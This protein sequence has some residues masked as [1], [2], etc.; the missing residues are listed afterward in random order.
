MPAFQE[1]R[2]EGLLRSSATCARALYAVGGGSG[3]GGNGEGGGGGRGGMEGTEAEMLVTLYAD[4]KSEV[5]TVVGLLARESNEEDMEE[6]AVE[7]SVTRV[8]SRTTD[9]GDTVT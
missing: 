8:I 1:V 4:V 5:K 3:E 9:P 7:L 6:K 2:D